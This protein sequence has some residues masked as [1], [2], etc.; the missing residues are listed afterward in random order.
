MEWKLLAWGLLNG[1]FFV[2]EALAKQ[3]ADSPLM[4]SLPHSMFNFICVFSG[5]TYIIV[6]IAVN[7]TGYAVGVG[8]V[9]LVLNK[10]LTLN[11]AKVLVGTYYFLGVAVSLMNFLRK[12]S[13]AR[14]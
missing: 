3:F 1:V 5:A 11:G 12:H 9:T 8:G 4:Q 7:L 13:F 2:V 10:L 14:D 6:L